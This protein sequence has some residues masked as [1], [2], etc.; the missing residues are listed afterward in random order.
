MRLFYQSAGVLTLTLITVLSYAETLFESRGQ[1][2]QLIE[3]YTSEGC[4]SCPPADQK[5]AAILGHPG[6][7]SKLVPVAFHVDY[8]DYLGWQDR[9]ARAGFSDRQRQLRAHGRVSAVYTPGWVIDGKEWRGYFKGDPM[10]APVVRDGGVLKARFDRNSVE[11][12]Y[13]PAEPV[14]GKLHAYMVVLGFDYVSRVKAG[15]NRGMELMHQFVVLDEQHALGEG[16]W[17]FEL[18]ADSETGGGRKALAVWVSAAGKV[19]PL[20]V[21][22]GWVK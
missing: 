21:L 16:Q 22:G 11:V 4:S 1:P 8:W 10:P 15:E 5:L 7:W 20:Q 2:A 3:L 14:P 9:F 6:L 19:E 13:T 17:R 12:R 18:P